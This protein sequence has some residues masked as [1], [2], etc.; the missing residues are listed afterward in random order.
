METK[1]CVKD[2]E[3]LGVHG[4]F[5]LAKSRASKREGN[6]NPL[7]YSNLGNPIDKGPW[8]ATVHG[9]QRV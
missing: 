4:M 1:H 2:M 3:E 8:E 5:H 9:V 7:Q 6:G